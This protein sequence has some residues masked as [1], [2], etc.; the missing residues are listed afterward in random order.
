MVK[1]IFDSDNGI[2]HEVCD[3]DYQDFG[4]SNLKKM[5]DFESPCPGCGNFQIAG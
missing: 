4:F 2:G 3:L 1:I 5:S